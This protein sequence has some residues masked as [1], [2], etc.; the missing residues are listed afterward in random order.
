MAEERFNPDKWYETDDKGNKTFN[1]SN[2]NVRNISK[3]DYGQVL[4]LFDKEMDYSKRD[5]DIR[6][7]HNIISNLMA[8]YNLS[9]NESIKSRALEKYQSYLDCVARTADKNKDKYHYYE[10]FQAVRATQGIRRIYNYSQSFENRANTLLDEYYAK[11]MENPEY[12]KDF[13]KTRNRDEFTKPYFEAAK[14]RYE[15]AHAQSQTQENQNT[16][17]ATPSNPKDPLKEA[18]KDAIEQLKKLQAERGWNDEA[19]KEHIS[20]INELT[21][22]EA[23]QKYLEKQKNQDSSQAD[24]NTQEDE[25]T[26]EGEA[27]QETTDRSTATTEE[28]TASEDK[29]KKSTTVNEVDPN[30]ISGEENTDTEHKDEPEWKKLRREEWE[31]YATQERQEFKLLSEDK[32][33]DLNMSVGGTSINY[34]NDHEVTMANTDEYSKFVKLIEIEKKAHTDVINFG[35]IQSEDY[36]SKLA[37]ACLQVGLE[38]KNGPKHIDLSLDCFKNLDDA[39]KQ[40]IEAYNQKQ[41]ER[42]QS[43]QSEQGNESKPEPTA[44]GN[45]NN[46]GNEGKPESTTDGNGNSNG[47]GNEN[48]PEPTAADTKN[49]TQ[50]EYQKLYEE[51]LAELK[52]KKE[53][54]ESVD[55][56]SIKDPVDRILTY[57]AAKEN[58]LKIENLNNNEFLIDKR[59]HGDRQGDITTTLNALP[60][61]AFKQVDLHEKRVKSLRKIK[62]M[63]KKGELNEGE[64]YEARRVKDADGKDKLDDKGQ[65]IYELDENGNKIY[66][67]KKSQLNTYKDGNKTKINREDVEYTKDKD[68]RCNYQYTIDEQ[69]KLRIYKE[70]E[71][72]G[73]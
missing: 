17:E 44:E 71:N 30:K 20:K 38:M 21:S 47:E 48:K 66:D 12:F 25:A 45:A 51:K 57:A 36:K 60:E 55:F 11:A 62:R 56:S 63:I 67:R 13:E 29:P 3:D 39:T 40:K 34:A 43:N 49:K 23:I 9:D 26:Q 65:P 7:D 22:L 58:K 18:Q 54:G 6:L 68:G 35:E 2:M 53:K 52:A 1:P 10:I 5:T 69:T 31:K 59:Q 19:L 27:T 37:A 24:E 72:R 15:E 32:A 46:A 70:R 64:Y 16:S 73:H 42:E 14:K 33:P 8:I 28:N 61:E 50:E 4:D 41:A